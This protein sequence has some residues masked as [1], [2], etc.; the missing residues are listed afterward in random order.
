MADIKVRLGSE[1]AIKVLSTFG[2]TGAGFGTFASDVKINGTTTSSSTT[3]GALVVS[4][5]V[6]IANNVYIGR[7]LNV[8][9]N[10]TLTG[11]LIVQG[12]T[13][14]G[15]SGSDILTVIGVSTFTGSI[16]HSGVFTNIGGA[17]ID[18]IELVRM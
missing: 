9:A 8:T 14:L 6:G 2:N 11:N 1:N 3:T 18:N 12:N 5:G 17:I 7:S 4:G 10:Q 15:N 13:N 16:T